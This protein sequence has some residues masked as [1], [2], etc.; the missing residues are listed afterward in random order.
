MICLWQ[1]ANTLEQLRRWLLVKLE[2]TNTGGL[3]SFG[4]EIA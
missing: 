1:K 3:H 4:I 2:N